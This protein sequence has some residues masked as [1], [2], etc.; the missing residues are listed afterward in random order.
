MNNTAM[1]FFWQTLKNSEYD[2]GRY[3]IV[4]VIDL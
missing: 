4:V 3:S 2:D 1:E